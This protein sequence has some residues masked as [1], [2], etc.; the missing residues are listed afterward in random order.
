MP[1]ELEHHTVPQHA[2][3]KSNERYKDEKLLYN[4]LTGMLQGFQIYPLQNH[5]N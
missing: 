1:L 4:G 5:R 2:E 3:K